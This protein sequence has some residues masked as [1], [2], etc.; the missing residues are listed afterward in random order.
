MPPARSPHQQRVEVLE[1][2]ARIAGF[3]VETLVFP[4]G[5]RPDVLRGCS[6]SRRLFI[7]D[8][9]DTESPGC[10]ATRLRLT[11]YAAWST[12]LA[13]NHVLALGVPT[14]SDLPGWKWLLSNVCR[15]VGYGDA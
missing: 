9:K 2:M 7:G 11:R 15:D 13:S 1:E 10:T 3:D 8:A 12:S 14:T 6:E 4:D 5:T